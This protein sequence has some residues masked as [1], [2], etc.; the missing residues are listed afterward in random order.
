MATNDDAVLHSYE[1]PQYS[2]EGSSLT[3]MIFPS[4]TVLSREAIACLA[5]AD[6]GMQTSP[7]FKDRPFNEFLFTFA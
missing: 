4:K 1:P 7:L 3:E 6:T 2:S 5:C